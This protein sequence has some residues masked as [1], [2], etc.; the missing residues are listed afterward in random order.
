MFYQSD[1]VHLFKGEDYNLFEVRGIVAEVPKDV[2]VF[3]D[4]QEEFYAYETIIC[5]SVIFHILYFYPLL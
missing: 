1:E 3:N 5:V 2:N 4:Y